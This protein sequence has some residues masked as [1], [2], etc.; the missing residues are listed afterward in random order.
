M[1]QK[2]VKRGKVIILVSPPNDGDN[3]IILHDTNKSDDEQN[4]DDSEDYVENLSTQLN[5]GFPN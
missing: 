1:M 4:A 5:I 2:N 3:D